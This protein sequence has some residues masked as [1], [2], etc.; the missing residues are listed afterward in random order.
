MLTIAQRRIVIAAVLLFTVSAFVLSIPFAAAQDTTPTIEPSKTPTVTATVQA[1]AATPTVTQDLGILNPFTQG[2]LTL[3]TGNV[4]RPN[5]IYW[6]D[7]VLYVSCSGDS[8]IYEVNAEDGRTISYSAGTR[9]AHMLYVEPGSDERPVIW[10]ADF[11]INAVV[12][13]TRANTTTIA[14]DL[15]GPWGFLYLDDESFLVTEI[16]GGDLLRVTREGEVTS[17]LTGLANPTGIAM[18]GDFIYVANNGSTRRAIEWYPRTIV[19]DEGMDAADAGGG[20]ILSGVQNVTGLAL[21]DGMLY[22]AYAL[23][24]RGVV[25]RV[26]PLECMANGGCTNS[27]VEV[28]LFTELAAPLAG[29]TIA[30]NGRLYVHT[31]FAPDIYWVQLGD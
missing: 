24:T 21:H 10:S 17:L 11:G 29:L 8:T 15:N 19:N 18:E 30:P 28:V 26:N 9:N 23:G 6:F 4:Q 27:D 13:A 7:E 14:G 20:T 25:G 2:D 12:R 16:L 1:V 3:L 31:M 22:F 5:G